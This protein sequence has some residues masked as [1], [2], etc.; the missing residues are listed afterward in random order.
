MSFE[1]GR[2]WVY[3][4]DE[5]DGWGELGDE[6]ASSEEAIAE[7]IADPEILPGT[8]F[9]VGKMEKPPLPQIDGEAICETIGEQAVEEFGEELVEDWLDQSWLNDKLEGERDAKMKELGDELTL[10]FREWLIKNKL[11]PEFFSVDSVEKHK[12]P[13]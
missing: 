1:D 5:E 8:T 9:F 3:S 12:K 13:L 10:V 4:A 6:Y 7:A 2:T 11:L